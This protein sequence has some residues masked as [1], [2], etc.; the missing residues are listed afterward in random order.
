MQ[1]NTFVT[2]GSKIKTNKGLE[3]TLI[4]KGDLN[5]DGKISLI[6]ISK[7]KKAYLQIETLSEIQEKAADINQDGKMSLMDIS[8]I[9]KV[10]LGIE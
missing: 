5:G 7:M 6:D 2:T 3:Y 1:D 4:V 10:Y 9:K 8:K